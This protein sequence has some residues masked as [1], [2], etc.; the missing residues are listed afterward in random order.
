MLLKGAFQAVL[1]EMWLFF[2]FPEE[3]DLKAKWLKAI[4]WEGLVVNSH[5]VCELHFESGR[6]FVALCHHFT[7]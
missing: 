5:K 6:V 4:G 1:L 7:H 2:K 3:L